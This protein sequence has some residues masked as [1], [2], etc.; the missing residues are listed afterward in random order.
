MNDV[1]AVQI[2]FAEHYSNIFGRQ[3]GLSHRYMVYQDT[4]L[5]INSLNAE[6]IYY[7]TIEAFNENGRTDSGILLQARSDCQ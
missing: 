7:F 2:N 5:S 1:C 4:I 3:K 6:I